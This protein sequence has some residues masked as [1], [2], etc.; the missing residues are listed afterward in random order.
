[1]DQ[2]GI[3]TVA[4]SLEVERTK[5]GVF[6][7]INWTLEDSML[8]YFALYWDKII[9]ISAPPFG[10]NLTGYSASLAEAGILSKVIGHNPH[11]ETEAPDLRHYDNIEDALPLIFDRHV[12]TGYY[13]QAVIKEMMKKLNE[14]TGCDW[15]VHNGFKGMSIPN[16]YM[17]ELATAKVE[18]NGCLPIPISKVS[19]DDILNF[20]ESRKDEFLSLRGT[21]DELY[22][23]I[24]RSGDVKFAK[25][26][27]IQQLQKSIVELNKVSKE[28]FGLCHLVDRKVSLNLNAGVVKDAIIAGSIVGAYTSPLFGVGSAL[29]TGLVSSIQITA[30]ISKELK[31]STNKMKLSYLSSLHGK[32]WI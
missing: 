5:A 27:K 30:E 32:G 31:N 3:I 29:A 25:N 2:Q 12:K 7:G 1:M 18:L 9:F 4:P 13:A 15:T 21:L 11:F 17:S 26:Y 16:E 24:S 19:I 8:S 28:K 23:E 14:N 22:M 10:Q 6:L 20:K